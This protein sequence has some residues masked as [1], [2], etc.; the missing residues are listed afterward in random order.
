VLGYDLLYRAD[1]GKANVKIAI[2]IRAVIIIFVLVLVA[3]LVGLW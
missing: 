3:K 2:A 1:I